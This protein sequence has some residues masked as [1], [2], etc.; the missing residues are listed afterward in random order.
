[1]LD[2]WRSGSDTL[3][4]VGNVLWKSVATVVGAAAVALVMLWVVL[5]GRAWAWIPFIIA[6]GIFVREL[7]YLQRRRRPP[8]AR[9]DE[10]RRERGPDR[11]A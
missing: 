2:R 1:M 11:R 5:R 8:D 3:G 6:F 9:F 7:R 4:P 10:P